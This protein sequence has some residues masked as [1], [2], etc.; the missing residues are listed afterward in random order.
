MLQPLAGKLGARPQSKHC[1][2]PDVLSEARPVIQYR[3][4]GPYNIM[5]NKEGRIT[6]VIDWGN[7]LSVEPMGLSLSCG[8]FPRLYLVAKVGSRGTG[9]ADA[10]GILGCLLGRG[11]D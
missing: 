7:R 10:K 9:K 5:R 8:N 11:K 3:H 2:V 4:N 6:K 1:N